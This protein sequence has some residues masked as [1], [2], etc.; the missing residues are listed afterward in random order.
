MNVSYLNNPRKMP[1][2]VQTFS[3]IREE[4]YVYVDKTDLMFKLVSSP[5]RFI[6]L[7]RP[8]RF[9]KS[10]LLSTLKSYFLGQKELFKGL[11]AERLEEERGKDAWAE[12]PVFHFDFTGKS[13]ANPEAV[14][15]RLGFTISEYEKIYGKAE[16]ADE[17]EDRFF[18]LLKNAHEQTGK[19]SVVLIDEYDNPLLE[20]FEEGKG[21]SEAVKKRLRAFYE[22]LKG[23]DPHIRFAMLT[24]VTKFA[25]LSVFSALNQL[26]DITLSKDYGTICG[27]TQEELE[28]DFQ[29]EIKA[30]GEKNGLTCEQT[31][32]KLKEKYNGY[33]FNGEGIR[34]YNP[35]ST[36]R[37]FD[38]REFGNYW[39]GS[40]TPTFLVNEIERT[41][42][43]LSGLTEDVSISKNKLENYRPGTEDI[44]P[45]LY[46]A[47]YLTI[48]KAD[49]ATGEFVLGF[50]NQEVEIGFLE[51]LLE[52]FV[53]SRIKDYTG[54]SANAFVRNL[55]DGNAEEFM[56]RLSAFYA[57]IPYDLAGDR[58][59]DFQKIF[60]ILFSLMGQL[61][62]VEEHTSKGSSDA[63]VET[64]KQVYVF[65]FKL[66]GGTVE[67]ALKQIEEK[68]YAKKYEDNPEEKR[69]IIKLG[70]VF[71][72]EK[73]E[74]REWGEAL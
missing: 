35:F 58:E 16:T 53:F 1:V 25:R 18:A 57:A 14:N 32:E 73:K 21:E 68:G 52:H 70:V 4:G 71:D 44:I 34:V 67:E 47:G 37:A 30:L 74:L 2:G 39:Y 51:N 49:D 24:G 6:F 72:P 50:P 69:K 46:Q 9:G 40:G 23:A 31:I 64:E 15:V 20:N 13:Y 7:S 43:S 10:L 62:K 19:K 63:V 11:A 29:P 36:V 33:D 38:D 3:T 5:S 22:V 42:L 65:E 61:A 17:I 27:I 66:T 56:N 8:R 41:G 60:F 54:F 12:H 28:R 26:K 59:K 45:L 55:R 48:K